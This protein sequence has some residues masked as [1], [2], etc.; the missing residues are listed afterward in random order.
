VTTLRTPTAPAVPA[1]GLGVVAVLA[2]TA[3]WSF[4]GVLGKS[5][6][7]SGVVISFWRLWMAS[8]LF[9]VLVVA[10]RSVPAWREMRGA[11]P[12]GVLF[13]INL[14]LFFS[15]INHTTVANALI[16][17]A[18]TPV[19]MLPI[20]V[21]Y[22][23]ERATPIKIVCA[24]VAVAGVVVAVLSAP[25]AAAGGGRTALGDGLAVAS[26]VVWICYLTAI[27]RARA[28]LATVP[29]MFTVS[30][31]AAVTVTPLALLGPYD[32]GAVDGV[33][34]WW[35]VLLTL[36]PGALGHGLIAW[37]QRHVDATVTSVLIQGEPVGATIAA[38]ALLGETV[39]GAQAGAM[40]VVVA[41][42]AVLAVQSTR[43][44]AVPAPA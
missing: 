18:L 3:A 39:T 26:L 4:G 31:V 32:L 9:G 43:T 35:L 21:R 11:A 24:L 5:V 23:G 6:G 38:A 42:L 28:H 17:G 30:L 14:C 41:A 27:K 22:L 16:V 25:D 36:V 10:T 44:R 40:A 33:G 13:G 20:A 8:A 2:A 37:A 15:A 12:A 34:W 1:S 19:V 29:F 7:A